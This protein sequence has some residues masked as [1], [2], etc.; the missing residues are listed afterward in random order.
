MAPDVAQRE[1][2]RKSIFGGRKEKIV[3]ANKPLMN[4]GG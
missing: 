1:T 4:A 2:K 3:T